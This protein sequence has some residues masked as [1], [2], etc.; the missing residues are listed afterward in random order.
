MLDADAADLQWLDD[1]AFDE[2]SDLLITPSL[3]FF[4]ESRHVGVSPAPAFEVGSG[5]TRHEVFNR[6]E[7]VFSE[8]SEQVSSNPRQR[9]ADTAGKASAR[10]EKKAEQNRRAVCVCHAFSAALLHP[11]RRPRGVAGAAEWHM[12]TCTA[13]TV[14]MPSHI[15]LIALPTVA[16]LA[17]D[18]RA[19]VAI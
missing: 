10:L 9:K 12:S 15:G 11:D 5:S 8:V 17:G 2:T 18:E 4:D 19:S 7:A 14:Y 3:A 16:V 6:P 1:F 13:C